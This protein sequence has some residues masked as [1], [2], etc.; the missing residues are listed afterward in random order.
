LY[1]LQVI[2]SRLTQLERTLAGLDDSARLRTLA[3]QVRAEEEAAAADLKA[4]QARLRTLELGL[5]TTVDKSRKIEQDL[6]SGRIGN[7]K[8]LTA[9]QDDVASLGRQRRR[10]EDEMLAL[11]EETEQLAKT[12]G[13]LEAQR[14]ARE[15][16]LEEYLVQ[17][18]AH[19]RTLAAE[20]E[21]LRGTRETKA[22]EI[23]RDL[24]RRYERLRPRKE[25][26]AV[27]AVTQGICEGCHVAI[28]EGRAA[29]IL[30]GTRVFTCE[31]CGRILYV[32]GG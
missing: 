18:Q 27:A 2:D 11:M 4:K 17:Y 7:P 22:A 24:L 32:Q 12:V 28:P 5:Q 10:S 31:E 20:F 29:E 19:A 14:Q 26:V 1:E 6:Y 13:T 15:R 23:D 8:E 25:G 16:E 9:M 30:E 3:E 21:T